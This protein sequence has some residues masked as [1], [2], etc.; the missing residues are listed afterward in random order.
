MRPAYG[1]AIDV[2]NF[3]GYLTPEI[4]AAWKAA[5]VTRVIVRASTERANSIA[6]ARQQMAACQEAG[7]ELE[8][9]VWLYWFRDLPSAVQIR[10]ALATC[11]GYP[12][13]RLWLDCEG[14]TVLDPHEMVAVIAEAVMTCEDAGMLTGQYTR[15]EWWRRVTDDSRDFAHL[16]LWDCE[17]GDPELG[18]FVAYGGWPKRA[19]RQYEFDVPLGGGP[20]VDLNVYQDHAYGDPAKPAAG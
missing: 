14:D 7:L 18:G 2:S 16:P 5:G 20:R 12:V 19:M 6:I 17:L 3:S 10:E 4:I 11:D 9:Y 15:R 8:G 1:L 13:R